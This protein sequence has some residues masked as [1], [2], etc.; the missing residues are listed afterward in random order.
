MATNFSP[1]VAFSGRFLL[2]IAGMR[3]L[4]SEISVGIIAAALLDLGKTISLTG[5]K[6]R[7]LLW[8]CWAAEGSH[9]RG[10]DRD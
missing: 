2:L 9:E 3:G 4:L 6:R 7:S 10:R 8:P 1:N 5:S